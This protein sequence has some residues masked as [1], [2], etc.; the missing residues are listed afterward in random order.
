[1]PDQQRK[2]M[3]PTDG[4]QQTM[5]AVDFKA[6]V[7]VYCKDGQHG[8]LAKVVVDAKSQVVTDL[9]VKSRQPA[10][11]ARVLPASLVESATQEAILLAI[12]GEEFE[13]YSEYHR[14]DDIDVTN[15]PTSLPRPGS[16]ELL[17]RGAY[18]CAARPAPPLLAM[19]EKM[20]RQR[21]R[22]KRQAAEAEAGTIPSPGN[23]RVEP[24][25]E[26]DDDEV[27]HLVVNQGVIFTDQHVI[28]VFFIKDAEDDLAFASHSA[29][30]RPADLPR[31]RDTEGELLLFRR[32]DQPRS[33]PS[34]PA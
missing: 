14:F 6:G 22:P 26:A 4:A 15:G 23:R 16:G 5:N 8:T 24:A 28:P 27:T 34:L 7:A 11:P 9:V 33:E 21:A 29:H 13:R 1:V 20:R 18:F 32:D 17:L 31:F 12:S 19:R 25:T 2:K 3:M 30:G 10:R